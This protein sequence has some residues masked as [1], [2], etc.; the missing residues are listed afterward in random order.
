MFNFIL[1]DELFPGHFL[2]CENLATYSILTTK[3]VPSCY[4]KQEKQDELKRETFGRNN[5]Q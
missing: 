3:K 4:V 1:F 5:Y 2:I